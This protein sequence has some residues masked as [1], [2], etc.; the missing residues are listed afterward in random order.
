MCGNWHTAHDTSLRGFVL[1][2]SDILIESNERCVKS[3]LGRPEILQV[4]VVPK[5]VGGDKVTNGGDLGA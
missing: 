4:F 5:I 2:R 3:R 1:E